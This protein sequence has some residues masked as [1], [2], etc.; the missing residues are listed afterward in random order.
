M[1]I[2]GAGM[3]GLIAG[4]MNGGAKILEASSAL[5]DNHYVRLNAL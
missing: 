2:I 3:A 4:I 5:P 1:Y